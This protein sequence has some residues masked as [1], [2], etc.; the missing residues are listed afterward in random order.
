MYSEVTPYTME[1][2]RKYHCGHTFW[3]NQI[4]I[5]TLNV[6]TKEIVTVHLYFMVKLG[7]KCY[8]ECKY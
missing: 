4:E 2:L 6:N 3:T 5:I 8:F 1:I 7:S